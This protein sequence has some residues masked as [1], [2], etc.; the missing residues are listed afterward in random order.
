M[1]LKEY[2]KGCQITAWGKRRLI[3]AVMA[4]SIWF[5]RVKKDVKLVIWQGF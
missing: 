3:S 1:A 4:E 5:C 2:A